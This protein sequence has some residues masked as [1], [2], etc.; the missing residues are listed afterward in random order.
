MLVAHRFRF[1]WLLV[2]LAGSS[3]VRAGRAANPVVGPPAALATNLSYIN[4]A[5]GVY[6][7]QYQLYADCSAVI[8]TE[9]LPILQYQGTG[10]DTGRD[11]A[12]AG[13]TARF[14]RRAGETGN[15]Y[16]PY[17]GDNRCDT[18]SA[19]VNYKTHTFGAL[20]FLGTDPTARCVRWTLSVRYGTRT[21]SRNLIA[22]PTQLLYTE[23][24]LNTADVNDDS[25]P[26]S[27]GWGYSR[28]PIAFI[29]DSTAPSE[30]VTLFHD[31]D[32]IGANSSPLDSLAFAFEEGSWTGPQQALAYQPGFSIVRPFPTVPGQPLVLDPL[33][34]TL[35]FQAASAYVPNTPPALGHNKYA[36]AMRVTSWRRRFGTNQRV[37]TGSI[38]L[39]TTLVLFACPPPPAPAV[40]YPLDSGAVAGMPDTLQVWLGEPD[41]VR[42]RVSQVECRDSLRLFFISNQVPLGAAVSGGRHT[43][44]QS[45]VLINW[46]DTLDA[47]PGYYPLTIRASCQSCPLTVSTDFQF[48]LDV[49]RRPVAPATADEPAHARATAAPNPFADETHLNLELAAPLPHATALLLYDGLGRLVDRLPVAAGPAGVRRLTW[50]PH[51]AVAAGLYYG[52]CPAIKGALVVRRL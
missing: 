13:N 51:A 42:L 44:T 33:T 49:R 20:I 12:N 3:S 46:A 52:R 19:A 15:P 6:F 8:D 17:S 22:D 30:V 16:C 9:V 7:V 25:S 23:A 35:R 31:P 48:I 32:N 39:E 21:P 4:V 18:A 5:P 34:G 11:K 10:C 50:R 47:Q 2:L 29:C 37:R 24:E 14:Q 28:P 45:E 43:R 41:T 1:A 40:V 38:R 26:A 27:S 36:L